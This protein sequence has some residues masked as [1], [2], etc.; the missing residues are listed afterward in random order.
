VFP[1]ALCYRA[2]H[3]SGIFSALPSAF[4]AL[5]PALVQ[6]KLR[7]VP[8]ERHKGSGR[9]VTRNSFNTIRKLTMPGVALARSGAAKAAHGSELLAGETEVASSVRKATTEKARHHTAS[10][11]PKSQ[12]VP[13]ES[14]ASRYPKPERVGL[15]TSRRANGCDQ[16]Q[17]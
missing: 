9:G 8:P 7:R 16:A 11:N 5:S 3:V 12:I 1:I 13:G 10:P 6:W 2:R 14:D 15:N 17:L 4:L